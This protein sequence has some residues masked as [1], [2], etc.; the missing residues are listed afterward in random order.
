M[1][2]VLRV[3]P[4]LRPRSRRRSPPGPGS[5]R[6]PARS[7]ASSA[8]SSEGGTDRPQD[9]GPS[10]S[11]SRTR[12]AAPRPRAQVSLGTEERAVGGKATCATPGASAPF[13]PL[14]TSA[15]TRPALSLELLA[16][17]WEPS[18]PEP[19]SPRDTLQRPG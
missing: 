1:Q 15:T 16:R 6:A 13:Q 10:S 18:C 8:G 19:R 7:P 12:P 9:A 4:A 14:P 5:A 3:R 11:A 2:Q 17:D